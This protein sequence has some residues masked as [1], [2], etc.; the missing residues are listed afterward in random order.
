M[1]K[2]Q[3]EYTSWGGPTYYTG[4][5]IKKSLLRVTQKRGKETSKLNKNEFGA[6][7]HAQANHI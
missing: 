5:H 4:T 6:P 3:K 7:F 1:R 2:Y